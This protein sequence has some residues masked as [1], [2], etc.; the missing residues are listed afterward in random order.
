MEDQPNIPRLPGRL[1]LLLAILI[2]GAANSITRK[3]TELGSQFVIEGRNPISVC[4]VLFVG[5]LC[6][7]ILLVVLHRRLLRSQPWRQLSFGNWI[8]L[9]IDTLLGAAIAPALIFTALSL[10]MVNNIVLIS[11]IDTPLTLI[12]SVWLLQEKINRWIV[13]GAAMSFLG[14]M[15]TILLQPPNPNAMVMGL[16]IGRGEFLTILAT[17]C[18]VSSTLI[19][20]ASLP[21]IPLGFF[22]IF[23]NLVGTGIFAITAVVLYT[24]SHFMDITA[25][26]LWQWMLIY[27]TVI[28]V[29]GQFCWFNGLKF[30]SAGE[31]ALASAFSPITG[32]L[33]AYMILAEAP[34]PAQY[35]GGFV[36]I[37]G[38]GLNQFGLSR[39][40]HPASQKPK[41][42][43]AAI[44]FKGI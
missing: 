17:I 10:T 8:A 20:K 39:L 27:S 36:I 7:L 6:A 41:A 13:A 38:I 29:G 23:R 43:D 30:S 31:V 42:I 12:L 9:S 2:F 14:A 16:A 24:P 22:S 37:C 15:L 33:A 35:M 40:Q 32:I 1:Y 28:V 26:I 25:P 44:G 19:S 18:L 11:E 21:E 34:T 3:L 5:N 4:N